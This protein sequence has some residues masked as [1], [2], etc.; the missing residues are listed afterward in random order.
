MFVEV[1]AKELVIGVKYAILVSH[2][3]YKY[4]TGTFKLH[5]GNVGRTF[6]YM[7]DHS[8]IE[9]IDTYSALRTMQNMDKHIS[10]YAFVPK[11]ERI[12]QQIEKR[13]LDKILKRLINDDFAW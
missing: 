4:C 12:Q 7:K 11:K 10:Y 1:D 9:N 2:D 13:A 3:T 5:R 6:H 8:G